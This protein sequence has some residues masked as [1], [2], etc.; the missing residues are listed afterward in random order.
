MVQQHICW[1]LP[2]VCPPVRPCGQVRALYASCAGPAKVSTF[3]T[4]FFAL[5]VCLCVCIGCAFFRTYSLFLPVCVRTCVCL[6]L[7]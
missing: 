7:S 6:S 5:C 1:F 3:G 2:S 4:S